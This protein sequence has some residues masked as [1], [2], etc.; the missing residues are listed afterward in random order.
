[1]LLFFIQSMRFFSIPDKPTP[2]P[3]RINGLDDFLR[4]ANIESLILSQSN[5]CLI[6]LGFKLIFFL[7]NFFECS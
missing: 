3:K 4:L 6:E 5:C 2:A 1:M 7:T